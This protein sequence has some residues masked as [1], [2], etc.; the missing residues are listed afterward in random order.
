MRPA[1]LIHGPTASG[2]TKLAIALA[3]RLD[4]EIVNADAMQ[5]YR[6]LEVLTA[7]PDAAELAAA[8]HHLFGHVDATE[9]HSAGD[10]V[11]EASADIARIAGAEK[12]P[13]VVGGTGLYL[14]ALT[15]GLSDIP[16]V[17]DGAREAARARVASDLSGARAE[18][19]ARDPQSA[20]RIE[21]HD[22]QR[23][24]RALEVLLETG[25]PLS[26]F[27]GK[28]TPVLAA[29]KLARRHAHAAARRALPAHRPARGRDDEG[30]RA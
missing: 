10:W 4:G 26:H 11:K 18:L 6:D 8:P 22:R 24:A 12:V 5:C 29:R 1:I 23:T 20:Q 17:G 15:D 25:L 13:I 19:E 28:A 27:H 21:P 2:K 30:W 7:R 14:T 3:R 9:R 16:P